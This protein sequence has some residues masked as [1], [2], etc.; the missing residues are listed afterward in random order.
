MSLP[1]MRIVGEPGKRSRRAWSS[2]WISIRST[3][4]STPSSRRI[5]SRSASAL[6]CDGQ[7]SHQRSSTVMYL[8][9]LDLRVLDRAVARAGLEP[10]DRVHRVHAGGHLAEDGVLA[11]EPRGGLGGDDE[12]LAAVRVRAAVRHRERAALDLVLVDL[13]LELVAGAA[14]ARALRA[15]ALDHE[16]RDHA[17]EDEAVVVAVA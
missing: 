3:R 2:S 14:G 9:A 13:V 6:G 12:E 5:R 8:H 10:L 17:V 1:S 4:A 7:P 15:A 16:V 11:V